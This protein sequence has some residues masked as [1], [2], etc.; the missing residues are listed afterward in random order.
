VDSRSGL[1]HRRRARAGGASSP[2]AT[3]SG[4]HRRLGRIFRNQKSA[5]PL[6]GLT[7]DWRDPLGDS[8]RVKGRACPIAC[9]AAGA[10]D[11]AAGSRDDCC[12]GGKDDNRRP[13]ARGGRAR[14]G[15]LL[16]SFPLFLPSCWSAWWTASATVGV[17]GGRLANRGSGHRRHVHLSSWRHRRPTWTMLVGIVRVTRRGQLGSPRRV[18]GLARPLAGVSGL[19]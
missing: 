5:F 7:P 14:F 15:A 16:L 8:S 10:L 12:A 18:G 4:S 6:F 1:D 2:E 9:D 17:T 19:A 13:P 3:S 11:A